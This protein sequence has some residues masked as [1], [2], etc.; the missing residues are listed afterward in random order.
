MTSPPKAKLKKLPFII[1]LL[2]FLF[3]EEAPSKISDAFCLSAISL[4]I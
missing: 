3:L 4:F 1:P 2:A